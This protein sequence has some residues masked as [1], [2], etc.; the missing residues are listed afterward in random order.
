MKNLLSIC[1]V[2]FYIFGYPQGKQKEKNVS[3]VSYEEMSIT[4]PD[5]FKDVPEQY[6]EMISKNVENPPK[7]YELSFNDNEALYK[8][9]QKK[10]ETPDNMNTG[11]IQMKHTVI[12]FGETMEMYE[13]FKTKAIITSANILDKEFLIFENFKKINWELINE[14]KMI[15]SFECKKAQA[16][17]GNEIIE[18]WYT[19]SI[20]TM[21]G[22]S[23]YWGLPGLI[24]E[25]KDK[26]RHYIATQIKENIPG[27]IKVPTKGKTISREEFK[28]LTAESANEWMKDKP[29][30]QVTT[31]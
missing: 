14:T 12:S 11:N 7:Y 13:D 4:P 1:F 31:Y 10:E 29:K 28:K 23:T 26:M 15:G 19:P 2:L 24:V 8:K 3:I 25:V 20:P 18:A 9:S 6:R 27:E 22:P 30:F 16:K 17:M 21:A 5:A